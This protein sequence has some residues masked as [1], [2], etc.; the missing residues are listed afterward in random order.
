[1]RTY[2]ETAIL[3]SILC[4]SAGCSV[5]ILGLLIYCLM[6][7]PRIGVTALV[8]LIGVAVWFV[9]EIRGADKYLIDHPEYT[10]ED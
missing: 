1:M 5:I 2:R 8:G 3:A 9:L 7:H 4:L 10:G 6:Y